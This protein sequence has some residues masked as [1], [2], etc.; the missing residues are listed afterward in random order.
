MAFDPHHRIHS[1]EILDLGTASEADVRQSLRDL[2]RVNTLL[3]G[4]RVLLKL[5][6]EQLRRTGLREF[7]LLDLGT[8]GG[9]LLLALARWCRARGYTSRLV[10]LDRQFRHLRFA[11]L[12]R[13][14]SPDGLASAWSAVCADVFAL[15]FP[16]RSFDFVSISLLLHHFTDERAAEALRSFSRAAR[17][18]LL[19]NDLERRAVAYHFIR[20]APWFARSPVTRF[21]APASVQQGFLKEELEALARRA[22][23]ERYRVRKHLPYRLSLVAEVS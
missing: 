18:A 11:T 10:G 1:E 2:E 4:R 16:F 9:D 15:P 5:V 14:K 7:S 17:H 22:G 12:E 19:V 8:G 20:L 6:D 13:E 23:L 3:G 21:D